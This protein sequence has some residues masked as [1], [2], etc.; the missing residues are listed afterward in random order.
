MRAK[1]HGAGRL[2]DLDDEAALHLVAALS[3]VVGRYD[4][5]WDF[6]LPYMMCVQEAP[7]V[8]FDGADDWHLHIELLPPHRNPQRL[9][10][11]AS[12]ET[13]LGVYIND[14]LPESLAGLLR[15]VPVV[16]H[17][18]S[19][20]SVPTIVRAATAHDRAPTQ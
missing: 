17:D 16:E 2:G 12:V 1:A 5:L 11:R 6:P 4:G 19:G 10:V 9:K 18:W 7:P 3:D 14:T 13:A 8:A 20:V 15:A